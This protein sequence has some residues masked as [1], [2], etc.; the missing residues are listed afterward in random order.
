MARVKHKKQPSSFKF[1]IMIVDSYSSDCLMI[2]GETNK[3]K[4]VDNFLIFKTNLVMSF[5]DAVASSGDK[6]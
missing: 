6:M 1:Q 4:V 2:S 3:K 5:L